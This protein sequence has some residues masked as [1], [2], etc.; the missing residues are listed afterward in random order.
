MCTV[1][2]LPFCSSFSIGSLSFSFSN[3]IY[4][5]GR[6]LPAGWSGGAEPQPSKAGRSLWSGSGGPTSPARPASSGSPCPQNPVARPQNLAAGT[7]PRR[8]RVRPSTENHLPRKVPAGDVLQ[9]MVD[10]L[11]MNVSTRDVFVETV[12]VRISP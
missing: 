7:A 5:V 2:F 6:P 12:L 11:P 10:H 3:P 9:G 8:T 1:V 4:L